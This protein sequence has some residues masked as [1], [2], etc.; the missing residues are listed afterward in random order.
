MI[1]PV[2]HWREAGIKVSSARSPQ[3]D[4]IGDLLRGS[5][6]VAL[7]LHVG[8][9]YQVDFAGWHAIDEKKGFNLM[10]GECVRIRVDE[11]IETPWNVFGQ[12]CSKTSQ[13]ADGLLVA[14][15][16]VDPNFAGLLEPTVLNAGRKPVKV[17]QGLLFASV[18]FGTLDPAPD[19]PPRRGPE[20]VRGLQFA[21]RSMREKWEAARPYV[22]TGLVTLCVTIIARLILQ[23]F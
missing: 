2:E 11:R 4:P 17:T 1:L 10:P 5:E 20:Q 16:K 3:A 18:W 14:N 23:V 22:L 12:I 9:D 21:K 13:S 15:L 6:R 19:D 7:D 8:A